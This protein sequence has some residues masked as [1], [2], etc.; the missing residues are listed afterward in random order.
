MPFEQQWNYPLEQDV[1]FGYV[2]K[3]VEAP[4][5]HNPRLVLNGEDASVLS[6]LRTELLHCDSFAFSVAFVST[7]AIALLKQELVDF[8]DRNRGKGQIVTSDYLE[9]NSPAAFEELLN[10][11][12]LGIDVRVHSSHSFHPKGY[13]FTSADSVT[14]MVGSANL[15]ETALVTNHEWNLRVAA[16]TNSDLAEQFRTA[17]QQQA[18]DSAAL[19]PEWVRAY[20]DRYVAPPAR[21]RR[22]GLASI[23]LSEIARQRLEPNQMQLSALEAIAQVRAVGEKRGLV[24]SATGTGKTILSALDIRAF[25]P[26]RFLFVVHREQIL[27]RTIEEYQRVLGGSDADYGKLAGATRQ[28]DRRY[29]FATVQTLAKPETLRQFSPDTFDYIVIDETHRAGADQHR[30]LIDYFEPQFLLGMTATPERTDGFNIFELFD[31]N[32]PYEI[33]LNAALEADMLAPFHY[34]GIADVVYEGAITGTTDLGV[35]ISADR[36]RHLVRALEIYGQAGVAP[37]GLIFCS[38]KDEAHALSDALNH[39]ELRDRRLRTVALTG[40][41]SIAEREQQVA[42]LEAGE[43]DYI[44]TVDVFNEGVDIPSINQV[45][46]LRQTQSAIVF[47]QQLGR[48]LRKA[49][50]KEYLV[51]IDFIGNYANNFLIPIALFGDDSLNKESLRKNLI[52][53]EESGVLPGLSSVRFDKISQE[54]VLRAITESS[55]DSMQRLKAAVESMRNRV[56]RPPAL[57]DFYRF[58]S[59]DPVILATKVEHYPALLRKVL[60]T[61]QP[62]SSTEDRALALLTH[63]VLAGKRLHEFVLLALLLRRRKVTFN[64][65]QVALDEAGLSSP[66]LITA[67]VID[68]FTLAGNSEVETARYRLPI[69]IREADTVTLSPEFVSSYSAGGAFATAVDDLRKT[70]SA[71]TLDRYDRDSVFTVGRQYSR[72]D[73]LRNLGWP[74]K[75]ASTVYGYKVDEG[76]GVCPAFITL[77]KSDEVAASQ[78]YADELIDAQTMRW[79]SKSNR[80]LESKDVRAIRENRVDIHVFVKKDDAEGSDHYY[81]GRARVVGA[82]QTTMPND[83]GRLLPVVHFDL[84]FDEPIQRAL[85][86]YFHPTI[87][88]NSH[89]RPI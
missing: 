48:G 35:L 27:D 26:K 57:W 9:F 3:A 80:T 1:Y 32:V 24:I 58:E 84:R 70:G 68:T 11:R 17:V 16:Q 55:L 62:F 73:A 42:R 89:D 53:A 15:T 6:V 88:A 64:D 36:V 87:T 77:H 69:A 61:G 63:E 46:M 30:Q 13:V 20:T 28:V 25:N 40:D 59:V 23:D 41:D 50:G 74:V 44:L 8:R 22:A 86:D 56:G 39:S 72:K 4:Q 75:G 51:V 43:L 31:Y 14:A 83:Q 85:F 65:L 81:L 34:Y 76:R 7:R 71:I 54:R 47:V 45:I 2:S 21:P 66:E 67:S 10:L 18:A 33:R 82:E 78:A 12:N 29:L 19:T 37:R 49:E 79:A 38:R 52:S 60:K 5:T